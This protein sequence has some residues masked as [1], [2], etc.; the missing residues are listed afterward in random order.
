MA[1]CL[2]NFPSAHLPQASKIGGDWIILVEKTYTFIL[3]QSMKASILEG[4]ADL[5]DL[6]AKPV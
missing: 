3:L 4:R 6:I 1:F 2:Q 5:I